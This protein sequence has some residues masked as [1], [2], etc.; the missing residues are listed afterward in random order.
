MARSGVEGV[1]WPPV[2][3]PK[4]QLTWSIYAQLQRTQWWSAD[5]LA[6][7]QQEQ[8]GELL[9]FAHR[10]VPFYRERLT[11]CG[12][13]TS[14]F[15]WSAVPVLTRAD[16]QQHEKALLSSP[17]PNAHGPLG[18]FDSSG[19]T[20]VPVRVYKPRILRPLMAAV[21]LRHLSW[22]DRNLDATL[23]G[24][25]VVGDSPKALKFPGVSATGWG[26]GTELLEARG[27]SHLLDVSVPLDDQIRLLEAVRPTYLLTYPSNLRALLWRIEALGKQDSVSGISQVIS[28]SELV[29]QDLR[30]HCKVVLG[31][32]IV[33]E[34]STQEVGSI[35]LQCP[36][37]AHYHTHAETML[38]EVLDD[39]GQHCGP[40]DT[41]RVVVT[42][43]QNF[44]MP[45]LRYELGDYAEVGETC[46]CGRG[47]PVLTRIL[48]RQRNILTMPDGSHRWPLIGDGR[49]R[50]IAPI[51]QYQIVQTSLQHME[52]NLV[53][54]RELTEAEEAALIEWIQ[55]RM[56]YAF[57][58]CFRY[59]REIPRGP[60]GKY[61]EFISRLDPRP[62]E[63][64]QT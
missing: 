27:E 52:V 45:L 8:L 48:G 7:A 32:E 60:G 19:S 38:V 56:G 64:T 14:N 53:V 40:G 54:E 26:V 44:A 36:E 16:A 55:Q 24:I 13:G 20:G 5:Q 42:P 22:H 9:R 28:I 4:S 34:Y 29:Q 57:T 37:H 63:S 62:A 17:T 46:P 11:A 12:F 47:L 59:H 15:D 41:G 49:Y 23:V 30:E 2:P 39:A 31:A 50:D 21:G 25:R 1:A 58:L 18:R 6:A 35:A 51:M 43:L 10:F 33:D 3:A 61:D